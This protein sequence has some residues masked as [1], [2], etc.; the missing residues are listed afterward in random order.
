[1][2]LSLRLA[3]LLTA[4][5]TVVNAAAGLQDLRISQTRTE[6]L[7]GRLVIALPK[8]AV[9]AT[10]PRS[11]MAAATPQTE[12][13]QIEIEAG[14]Q[15]MT[16][17]VS[18]LFARVGNDFAG[19]AR[20]EIGSSAKSVRLR[21]IQLPAPLRA[22]EYVPITP[23]KDQDV[24]LV[25]GLFIAQADGTVQ[26]LAWYVNK[27]AASQ[28]E[29]AVKLAGAMAASAAAG[30][31]RFSTPAGELEVRS[32][33]KTKNV[34]ITVPQDFVITVQ[35]G[36]DFT[37][38]HVRKVRMLGDPEASIGIYLGDYP[39]PGGG[40]FT[41]DGM[42]LLFGKNVQWYRGQQEK[43]GKT[44][45]TAGGLV[46]LRPRVLESTAGN[47]Y[48]GASFA[49]VFLEAGDQLTLDELKKIAETL[50][51]AERQVPR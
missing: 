20:T 8:A 19:E 15:K 2:D 51:I 25:M 41:K 23:A 40:G 18:E 33:T 43:D 28:P 48:P 29:V 45:L 10:Y 4:A 47:E 22:I 31:R 9:S 13:T 42:D 26:Q 32:Y 12:T 3:V 24:N 6:V 49:D 30:Q 46:N 16:L 14:E 7:A 50:R 11:I 21:T 27:A 39:S 17:V 34:Y 44:V 35:Q 38:H 37:V 1:M 36:V 5:T